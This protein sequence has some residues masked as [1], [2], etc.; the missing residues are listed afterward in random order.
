MNLLEVQSS[1]R[2]SL[3]LDTRGHGAYSLR[4]FLMGN[5]KAGTT[6]VSSLSKDFLR[7]TST[8]RVS[9]NLAGRCRGSRV[10][11]GLGG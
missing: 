8:S 4:Y 1:W 9:K 2:K 6:V 5:P 7:P 3:F 10:K 11:G